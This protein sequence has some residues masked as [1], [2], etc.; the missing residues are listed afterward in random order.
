M[1]R[2]TPGFRQV[3]AL[4]VALLVI[5]CGQQAETWRVSELAFTASRSYDAGGGDRVR[6]DVRFSNQST[7]R[8][9]SIPAFWD[10]GDRF[11]VRF[12]PPEPGR[13]TYLKAQELTETVAV[14]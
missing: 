6:M 1:N 13:W 5:S 10:G 2:F 7:G 12:A 11:V 9:L 14:R 3:F 8:T 4:I